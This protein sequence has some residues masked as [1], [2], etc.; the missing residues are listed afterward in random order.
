[1][2]ENLFVLYVNAA[3]CARLQSGIS[4]SGQ[5]AAMQEGVDPGE[6][7]DLEEMETRRL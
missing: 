1:M 5:L 6:D 2:A 3:T 7:G 4:F